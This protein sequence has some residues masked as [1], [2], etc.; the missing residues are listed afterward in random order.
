MHPRRNKEKFQQPT[1]FER[2]RIIDFREGGFSYHAIGASVQRNSS[3][4][5]CEFRSRG[6]KST[7]QLE[8]LVVDDGF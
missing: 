4:E 2:R 8:K 7:E 1:K 5:S 6:P 3:T